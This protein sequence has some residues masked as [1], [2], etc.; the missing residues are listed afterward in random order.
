MTMIF[1]PN[2]D[3]VNHLKSK[4]VK[5]SYRGEVKL[6]K[7]ARPVGE[8]L[9][10][11]MKDAGITPA[12]AGSPC[13]FRVVEK[14]S[15]FVLSCGSSLHYVHKVELKTAKNGVEGTYTPDKRPGKFPLIKGCELLYCS[16]DYSTQ[17][18]VGYLQKSFAKDAK[19]VYFGDGKEISVLLVAQWLP[20]DD[21]KRLSGEEVPQSFVKEEDENGKVQYVYAVDEDG[22][23]LTDEKGEKIKIPLPPYRQIKLEN[24]VLSTKGNKIELV[25]SEEYTLDELQEL[26]NSYYGA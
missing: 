8:V 18:V 24:C 21:F 16:D 17:Y 20:S 6:V 22:N 15:D 9:A 1:K 10:K 2:M 19:P 11:K 3:T 23:E 14:A 26:K 7:K 4:L 13:P 12:E 5:C 25:T